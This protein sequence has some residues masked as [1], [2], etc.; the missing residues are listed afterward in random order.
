MFCGPLTKKYTCKATPQ[1]S[2]A[3]CLYLHG[4]GGPGDDSVQA[5]H[6]LGARARQCLAEL[7]P[8][9]SSQD[10]LW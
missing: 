2:F 6:G 5:G 8:L 3:W 4:F 9:R 7:A 1:K 10:D